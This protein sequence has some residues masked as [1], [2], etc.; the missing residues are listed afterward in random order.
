MITYIYASL[1]IYLYYLL[2]QEHFIYVPL[3]LTSK[4]LTT[5]PRNQETKE[6]GKLI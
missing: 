5:E 6:K 1:Y 2:T 3:R 4:Y